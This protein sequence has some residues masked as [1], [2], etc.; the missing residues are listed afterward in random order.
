MTRRVRPGDA[1]RFALVV[2]PSSH[3]LL[4]LAR[5]EPIVPAASIEP[6]PVSA[7]WDVPLSV[8][9]TLWG[10]ALG[11]VAGIGYVLW[12]TLGDMRQDL[13]AV[14]QEHQVLR[15][16][17]HLVAEALGELTELASRTRLPELARRVHALAAGRPGN[18][19]P[20]APPADPAIQLIAVRRGEQDLYRVLQERFEPAGV[21][22]I[23]DRRGMERRRAPGAGADPGSPGRPEDNRRHGERRGPPPPTWDPLGFVLA[24]GPIGS[25]GP[26]GPPGVVTHHAQGGPAGGAGFLTLPAEAQ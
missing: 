6:G 22:V 2:P 12:R 15:H 9:L 19:R 13:A 4:A 16:Q 23:W 24:P 8:L 20:D 5:L 25:A 11:L 17:L 1:V 21:A 18:G 3:G 14:K 10:V 26:G 7:G